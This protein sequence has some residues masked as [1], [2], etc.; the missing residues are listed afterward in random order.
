MTD[1]RR[2]PVHIKPEQIAAEIRTLG[3][4]IAKGTKLFNETRDQE[5]SIATTPKDEIWR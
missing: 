4:K 5:V 3:E 1:T 2:S